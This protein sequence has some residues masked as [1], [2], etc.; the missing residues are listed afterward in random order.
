MSARPEK[1]SLAH[2]DRLNQKTTETSKNEFI[3]CIF[4]RNLAENPDINIF[5]IIHVPLEDIQ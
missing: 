5:R 1:Y 2:E 3:N 4:Y